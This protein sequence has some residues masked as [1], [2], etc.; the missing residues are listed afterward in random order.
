MPNASAND[1]KTD[2]NLYG[3]TLKMNYKKILA[4][5]MALTLTASL[6]ACGSGS[7]GRRKSGCDHMG[8]FPGNESDSGY[9]RQHCRWRYL[10]RM[11]L[12]VY[13]SEK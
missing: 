13:L 7:G 3:G 12:L 11:C 8:E 6:T 1:Y 9:A 2:T 4:G 5:A 10:C